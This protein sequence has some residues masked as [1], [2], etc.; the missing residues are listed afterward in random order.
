MKWHALSPEQAA[1]ITTAADVDAFETKALKELGLEI[2]LVPPRYRSSYFN[3]IFSSPTG[4]SSGY[5]SYLWTEM[6]DRDSRKWFRDNGGLTRA[7]GD[8]YRATVLSKGGTMDYFQ[9]FEN[10]AGRAP[11]VTPMLAARGLTGEASDADETSD[12]KLPPRSVGAK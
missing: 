7:N 5:Y 9:M 1:E 12:G 2:G 4:Y 3:H 11:D 8:H 6:L 10:F